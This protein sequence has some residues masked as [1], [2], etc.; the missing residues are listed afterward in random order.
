[1]AVKFDDLIQTLQETKTPLTKSLV[2]RLSNLA[3]TE[4]EALTNAWGTIPT[5]RRYELMRRL[6]EMV[7]NDFDTDFSAVTRLALTDLSDNVREKAI[8]AC[9]VDESAVLLNRLLPIASIDKSP[10]VRAA[11]LTGLGRFILLGELGKFDRMLARQAENTTLR[12]YKRPGEPVEVRRRAL[13][14]ISNSSRPEIETLIRDA[15]NTG[16]APLQISAVYAMGRSCDEKWASIVLKEI[17][18]DSAAM[19][20]E[21]VRAAGEISLDDAVPALGNMIYDEDRQITEMIVWALGEIG[22]SEA[23]RILSDFSKY[24]EENEDDDLI[25]LVEDALAEAN[26]GGYVLDS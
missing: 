15:Y 5:E 22:S 26:L 23:R 13:E 7:E 17:S 9:V 11:A 18:N 10:A 2:R 21:A 12:I 8:E 19:R 1:M 25:E 24:A 6:A 14:A 20:F 4:A 3:P 16:E